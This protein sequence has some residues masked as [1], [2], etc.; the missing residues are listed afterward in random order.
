LRLKKKLSEKPSASVWSKKNKSVNKDRRKSA[1]L[2][3]VK[4][5]D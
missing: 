3:N 5:L 2:R 4:R 1:R